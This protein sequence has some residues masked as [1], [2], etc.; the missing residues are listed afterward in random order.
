MGLSVSL[1]SQW[2]MA[3]VK[4]ATFACLVYLFTLK[5][6]DTGAKEPKMIVGSTW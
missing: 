1:I 5:L 6:D 3:S 2:S 4:A